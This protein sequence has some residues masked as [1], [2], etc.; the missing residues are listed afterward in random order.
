MFRLRHWYTI[1]DWYAVVTWHCRHWYHL[2][3][4]SHHLPSSFTE[5]DYHAAV[6]A[7][8]CWIRFCHYLFTSI[9]IFRHADVILRQYWLRHWLACH[10]H[11]WR[12]LDGFAFTPWC[13]WHQYATG[14]FWLTCYAI[15]SARHLLLWQFLQAAW[16]ATA[17]NIY[18]LTLRHEP[19][20][21]LP[22]MRHALMPAISRHCYADIATLTLRLRLVCRH[23]GLGLRLR[24]HCRHFS[25]FRCRLFTRCLL[26]Y[27]N[28]ITGR[29]I[30]MPPL[31]PLISRAAPRL[32]CFYTWRVYFMNFIDVIIISLWCHHYFCLRFRL[33]WAVMFDTAWFLRWHDFCFIADFVIISWL[34]P[35]GY[36]WLFIYLAYATP[37]L[38]E[39]FGFERCLV[40][41]PSTPSS[42][43]GYV[44]QEWVG[45]KRF[46]ATRE[47]STQ[48]DSSPYNPG[49][50][51]PEK[52]AGMAGQSPTAGP[53]SPCLV[54]HPPSS[55]PPWFPG[56]FWPPECVPIS[57]NL[58]EVLEWVFLCGR[59]PPEQWKIGRLQVFCTPSR[60]QN[61][62]G[63]SNKSN[64]AQN[65]QGIT[66]A[67]GI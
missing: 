53:A 35:L 45:H 21:R 29:L 19:M 23:F 54:R 11:H 57:S 10:L 44:F 12:W 56:T 37:S 20:R 18:L 38:R 31:M 51:A 46:Q 9:L 65:R 5:A 66:C 60:N 6:S 36:C 55:S 16:D 63:Q 42:F 8:H 22:L 1:T 30:S 33:R 50:V 3:T 67:N 43:H 32:D 24:C 4:I 40:E 17:D 39:F 52:F 61:G 64:L 15:T 41:I 14:L 62:N 25:P 26:Q 13:H 7:S 27:Y 34:R 59:P 2:I 49:T 58:N 47:T 28:V 48:G